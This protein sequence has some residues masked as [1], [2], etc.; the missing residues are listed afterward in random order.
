MQIRVSGRRGDARRDVRFRPQLCVLERRDLPD[1]SP[2]T[3]YLQTNLVSD[4]AG[5]AAIRDT[6]LVN[7]WGLA[8]SSTSPFWVADNQTGVSTLY[9]GDV[10]STALSKLGLTVVIPGGSP[11]G[12]VFNNS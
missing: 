5:V 7:A 11:T 1:A 9:S 3:A 8:L 10:G 2:T 4:Q 6:S 12:V